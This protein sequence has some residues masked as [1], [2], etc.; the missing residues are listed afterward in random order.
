MKILAIDPGHKGAFVLHDGKSLFK[1]WPMPL[2]SDSKSKWVSYPKVHR[3]LQ[4]IQAEFHDVHVY[5]ERAKPMAMGSKGAFSYGRDFAA[6][7]I[8]IFSW[9][10]P[11]TYIEPSTWTRVIHEGIRNDL[12]TKAKSLVAVKR[13]LPKLVPKL[14][15]NIKGTYLDGPIDALLI[16][17]YAIN[18]HKKVYTESQDFY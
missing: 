9:S 8:A 11:C 18:R 1:W 10:I 14:P 17:H 4:R 7:E 13:L 3:L 6:L 2:E 12:Q 5:L 16:A 15:T